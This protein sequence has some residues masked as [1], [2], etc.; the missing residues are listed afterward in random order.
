LKASSDLNLYPSGTNTA[1]SSQD[2]VIQS[3]QTS[4]RALIGSFRDRTKSLSASSNDIKKLVREGHNPTIAKSIAGKFFGT[5]KVSFVAIDGT[6]SQDQQ[7]DMLLFYSGAFA[8]VGEVEF[9][10]ERCECGEVIEAE[11]ISNISTAI[12][13]YEED[14]SNI[15]GEETEAGIEVDIERL[16]SV[17][18]QFSE[19]YLAMKLLDENPELKVVILDRTLAGD[20]GHLIW[21][22]G[23][24]IKEKKCILKGIQTDS[25]IVTALDLDLARILHPN[26]KLGIPAPRSQFIKYSAINLLLMEGPR[27]QDSADYNMLLVKMGAKYTRLTK[28]VR[29]L[30]SFNQEHSFLHNKSGEKFLSIKPET[31][32]YWERVL[33]ATMK[34]AR[35]IFETPPGQHPLIYE[36]PSTNLESVNQNK[37]NKKWI[38]SADLEYLTLVMIYAL[39]RIAWEKNVLIIG[40][41]KDTAASELL[42]TVVPILRDAKKINIDSDM[43]KFNS[44]KQLLQTYSV[45]EADSIRAPWRTFEFDACFRTMVPYRSEVTGAPINQVTGAYKNLISGERMF[46]KSYVQLWQSESDHSVRS[47]VFSYDRPCYPEFDKPDELLLSHKDDNVSEEIQ[48]MIHFENDSELSHLVMDILCS[49]ASEVIP[50]CLGHNYPLFLADK[51]AKYVLDQMRAA[52]LSTVAFEMANSEFDQQILYGASFRDFRSEIENSRRSRR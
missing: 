8:Y 34:I 4:T 35:H 49:M 2:N 26:A 14:A 24:F 22:V 46:V 7:L 25:G 31:K 5:K 3:L 16:P 6:E 48:P 47:H 51:K 1:E 27:E 37:K 15:L 21:S 45:I 12:P 29:D 32:G 50:E 13:L 11:R 52:Y 30:S 41:I 19:Y 40:L 43:P 9:V 18:M 20:V 44:D 28:L 17:L 38:T 10:G 36:E 42:K 33:S 23:Q 39:L